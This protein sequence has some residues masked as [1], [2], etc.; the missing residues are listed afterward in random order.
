M[1][2]LKKTVLALVPLALSLATVSPSHAQEADPL[3]QAAASG[4][5]SLVQ[6]L[7]GTGQSP[8]AVDAE[9]NSVLMV[10]SANGQTDIAAMLVEA[11]ADANNEGWTALM[12]AA[13]N[14]HVPVSQGL[15]NSGADV[16]LRA[17]IGMTAIIM[18]AARGHAEVASFLLE[19]GAV[20]DDATPDG[21][22]SLM[23]AAEGGHGECV[24]ALIEH[25]ADVNAEAQGGFTA[26]AAAKNG[27]HN[28]VVWDLI[29]AGAIFTTSPGQ[30]PELQSNPDI[31]VPDS[32]MNA[33]I[34]GAVVVQFI[35]DTEG[36]VVEESIEI[37]ESPH[38]GLNDAVKQMFA[39]AVY[40]PAQF[41]G[42]P[43]K[44]RI[45]Q[46]MTFGG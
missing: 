27:G 9:G 45:R 34:S 23:A 11:G 2:I 26:L 22:T 24:S 15:V 42:K 19:N 6:L 33:D 10:A 30:L 35:I 3:F 17:N 21:R 18:A 37:I 14:G 46:S 25:G 5:A 1:K 8:T 32:L 40:T 39:G 38:E 4:D 28:Q 13:L 16:N 44:M 29:D 31:E 43:V 12:M 36:K 20:A 41:D 7:I